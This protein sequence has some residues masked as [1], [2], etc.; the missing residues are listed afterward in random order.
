MVIVVTLL[1]HGCPL[2][3]SVAAFGV[4]ARTVAA[5]RAWAGRQGQ[6][7]QAHLVE[8]P[9]DLGQVQA[10]D[11]RVTPP[12]GIV[13]MALALMVKTRL[14]LGGEVSKPV[15]GD[16]TFNSDDKILPRGRHNLEK[17]LRAGFHM[18]MDHNIAV[19]V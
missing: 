3:A 14:W 11:M 12:G 1:A 4:G 8:P 5:W 7:V 17:C 9:L 18:A 19:L 13:W 2:H 10:E 16:E 6:A 15:L